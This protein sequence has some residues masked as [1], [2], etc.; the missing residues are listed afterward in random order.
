MISTYMTIFLISIRR[1]FTIH[2]YCLFKELLWAINELPDLSKYHANS[3]MKRTS[4]FTARFPAGI[5]SKGIDFT[6]F[7]F[8][9]LLFCYLS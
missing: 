9:A 6:H 2:S 1:I 8:S 3:F 4:P 7:N 5:I